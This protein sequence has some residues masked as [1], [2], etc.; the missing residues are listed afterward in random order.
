MK[1]EYVNENAK[2]LKRK[3]FRHLLRIRRVGRAMFPA[4]HGAP[5]AT[6]V[7]FVAIR[8]FIASY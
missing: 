6:S 1:S 8:F 3:S 7:E 4:P 5:K 2:M